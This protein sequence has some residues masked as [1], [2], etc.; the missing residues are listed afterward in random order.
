MD[1][2][3]GALESS[4]MRRDGEESSSPPHPPDLPHS[5]SAPHALRRPH[6][7]GPLVRSVCF[8]DTFPEQRSTAGWGGVPTACKELAWK[9]LDHIV[10]SPPWSLSLHVPTA[11]SGDMANF[12][13]SPAPAA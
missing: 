11:S 12:F 3:I 6:N 8:G 2:V 9:L 10:E 1:R 5:S 7:K 13:Q 4:A